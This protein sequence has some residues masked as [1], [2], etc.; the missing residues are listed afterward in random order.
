MN[1]KRGEAT[2]PFERSDCLEAVLEHRHVVAT[3]Q[4]LMPLGD[5]HQRDAF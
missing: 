4:R 1:D 5:V 2:E 3:E